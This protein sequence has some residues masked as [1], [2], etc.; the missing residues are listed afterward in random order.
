MYGKT[1][2]TSLIKVSV[3]NIKLDFENRKMEVVVDFYV[4]HTPTTFEQP[5]ADGTIETIEG[6]EAYG[7]RKSFKLEPMNK[8]DLE[9]YLANYWQE[10]YQPLEPILQDLDSIKDLTIQ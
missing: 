8:A 3:Q 4:G 10:Y 1:F 2:L 9:A 5:T 7:F 6:Y